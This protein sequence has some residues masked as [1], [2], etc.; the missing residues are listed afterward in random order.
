MLDFPETAQQS[1]EH[2]RAALALIERHRV[3]LNP[4]NYA[5][6]YAYAARA[7]AE[8]V[9]AL[10]V[11]ISNRVDYTE[12]L[13]RGLWNRYLG[14]QPD[15]TGE[16]AREIGEKLHK[17][18]QDVMRL[19]DEAGADTKAY[20]KSL[21]SAAGQ[22]SGTGGLKAVREVIASLLAETQTMA[23]RTRA[24]ET[25]LEASAKE[26]D[27][28]RRAL[29]LT[30]RDAMTDAL[31]G[32]AN[33]KAFDIK[34][35]EGAMQVMET[36]EPLALLMAD[37]DHFKT[38]NDK[39]GH[40]MGDQVLK[41]VARTLSETLKGR[42][43]PARYGGEE[44]AIILPSTA[45]GPAVVVGE[46][47]RLRVS[48]RLLVRKDTQQEL[49]GITLSI[50]AAQFRMGEPLADLIDRADAALYRAKTEGRNRVAAE[51]PA[52]TVVAAAD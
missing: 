22:L 15:P 8:L 37:I 49:G 17:Q 50:G 12:E 5:I 24:L 48:S 28:L 45:I 38:F 14:S 51:E 27:E 16:S 18:L 42:D 36:G 34:L 44:F 52:P 43:T 30:R 32:I 47:I 3:R 20:G 33:R 2:A 1:A 10:D 26:A 7:S 29:E 13:G 31:T 4:R 39:H 11:V 23:E 40:Q 41:L 25:R 46:Q 35:R 21:R 19:L 9:K 6:W